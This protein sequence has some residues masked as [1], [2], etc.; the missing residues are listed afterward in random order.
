MKDKS[1]NIEHAQETSSAQRSFKQQTLRYTAVSGM[2]VA[3]SVVLQF[4]EFSVPFLI[5]E[6]IKMD[7][8]DLPAL[9]ASFSM[10]PM[11]GVTVSFLKNTIHLLQTTT[12]GVGELANFMISAVFVFTA[13]QFYKC[14]KTRENALKGSIAGA[15][16]AAVVSVP[17][18]YFITYPVY[19]NFMP[20]ETVLGAYQALVPWVETIFTSLMVFNAPFTLLKG[21]IVS[22]ITFAIYK[23]LSPIIKGKKRQ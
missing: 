19:Y 6:F 11:Y 10:G 9:I 1:T 7:F 20:E 21:L 22:A 3:V 16:I 12:G 23:P 17:V 15:F 5:P 8:S 13:G 14:K 2:L 4:F 18:N